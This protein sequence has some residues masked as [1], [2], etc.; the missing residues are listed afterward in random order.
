M[1]FK[2]ISSFIAI[3]ILLTPLAFNQSKETGA[4]TGTVLDEN[5]A[6]LPG[7]TVTLSSPKLMGTRSAITDYEGKY[8]FPA[9]PPGVYSVKAELP[10]FATIIQ[11]NVRL[12]T[13][14]SLTVDLVLKATTLEEEV[15][16]I[17]KAPTVD[18][19]T[20]ETAS[21][22]LTDEV[23]RNMPT[24]Q[25]AMDIVNL[26]PGVTQ[27]SAY[28]A[29]RSTGISYQVDG[30][31]VSDPEGGSAWVFV[32]YNII[33]EAKI[34]GIGLPAEYGAF[35][36]VI[37]NTIT[38]SGGNEFSGHVEFIFQ[39][40]KKG[41]WTAENN[42]AYIDDFPKLES[43]LTGMMN[44]GAHIGGPIKKDKLWFYLGAE[45]LR[46]KERPA[47]FQ[48]PN[49]RDYKQPRFFLKLTSQL[50]PRLHLTTFIENDTYNGIN[51]RA[52]A[53]HPTPETCVE[54]TSPD[55]VGNFALTA[56]L[57]PN[58][59]A[60]VKG[61]FFIGYYY[62]DPQGEGTAIFSAEQYQWLEN[63]NW[64]YKADRK[65]YQAN[66][67]ISHYAEDFIMGD[68]DFKFGTEFEYG[69]ARS[70][71]GY[72]G[73]NSWYI[74]DWFGSLYAY[75]YEGYDTNTNYTRNEIFAQDAWSITDNLTL[76]I[77]ARFS[78]M[79]GGVKGKSGSVYSTN[80]IAPRVGFAWDIFSDHTTVLKAHYGQF[81]EAMYTGIIDRLNP[82]GAFSD[83]VAYS[84]WDGEWYESWRVVPEVITLADKTKHPYMDQFTI[85]IERELFKD[86]SFGVSYIYRS[87]KDF[88]GQYDTLGQYEKIYVNDPVTGESVMA[89]NQLNPGERNRVIA[90]IK[91]GDPWILDNPY[92]TYQG[93]EFRLNKRMSNRWQLITSYIYSECKGTMDNSFGGDFGW[94]STIDPNSWIN[95]DGNCTRDPKHM[96][97][98]QGTYILPLNIWFNTHFTV[99]S[100]NTYTR[101]IRPRLDQGRATIYTEPHGS[102]RYSTRVN[103]DL[104]L[105]KTF[106][107]EDR[108]RLGLMMDIFNVFN[109]DTITR[110]G[111][112]AGYDWT[113]SDPGPDGHKIYGLVS[114]RAIRL[115]IRL[116]F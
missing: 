96:L 29:S 89:Y 90:N 9:L 104:R 27:N 63:S 28:G 26:A 5:R 71:F 54:Q 99:I 21:I 46:E 6:P 59:F 53:T 72:T 1:R 44:A 47:G 60:N 66:A 64:F 39:D 35:T 58:T 51:R 69:W 84:E 25:F 40:T 10:G 73:P 83:F 55:W 50:S 108:Y 41:F 65:R 76:N 56:I 98:I 22:T 17:A 48:E 100:G 32:D 23:L 116:L 106:I 42:K 8:R 36:G 37:F 74:Y 112:Q 7:V 105:E 78:M 103:L 111:A 81:T 12:S 91:E 20:S 31:D 67:S 33:E 87:W 115:G 15:T 49:F 62:L 97:K 109:S 14:V 57:S 18:V 2:A 113:P 30:V 114:P 86:A 92:R 85:G 102:H 94:A 68:H 95:R 79:R 11:E 107:L 82:P 3:L 19:K 43:P 45:Y 93:I 101:Y 75:Q 77:G 24:T 4:I 110:W 13:T 80:R 70:R 52:S 38:K 16:V 61:S 88:I 34:M